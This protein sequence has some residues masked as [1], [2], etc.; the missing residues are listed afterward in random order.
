MDEEQPVRC[1][2]CDWLGTFGQIERTVYQIH[3]LYERVSP[4]EIMPAGECPECEALCYVVDEAEPKPS[5]QWYREQ[6]KAL[7]EVKGE[8]EIDHDAEVS[9][10]GDDSDPGAYVQAWIWIDAPSDSYD[11]PVV[12]V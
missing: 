1:S 2:D 10:A 8:I 9:R 5:N 6:A 12:S 7:R 3:H 4:G 11:F